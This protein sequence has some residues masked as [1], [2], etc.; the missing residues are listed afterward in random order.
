MV[1]VHKFWVTKFCIGA[2]NNFSVI[3]AVLFLTHK[4]MYQFMCTEQKASDNSD[5]RRS[6]H[7]CQPSLRNLLHVSL[8]G[9]KNSKWRLHVWKIC[10][11]LGYHNITN[12]VVVTT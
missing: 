3:I 9:A 1:G 12:E 5:V 7:N 8:S 2:P 6:L 4:N 10:G 11:P